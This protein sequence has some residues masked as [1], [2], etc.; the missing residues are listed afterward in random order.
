MAYKKP[1]VGSRVRNA[2][3]SALSAPVRAYYGAK[4][5]R[6]NRE[7]GILK[8]ARQFSRVPNMTASGKVSDAA[9]YRSAAD[10]IRTR[11]RKGV[12]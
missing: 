7:A 6:R 11:Y 2:V 4:T 9:K 12:R 8:T 3:G 1:S 5:A 10:A